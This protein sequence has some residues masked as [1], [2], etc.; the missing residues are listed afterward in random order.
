LYQN[1]NETVLLILLLQKFRLFM[2]QHACRRFIRRTTVSQSGL[3]VPPMKNPI[4]KTKI[5]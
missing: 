1:I 3:P 2:N 4:L 5:L